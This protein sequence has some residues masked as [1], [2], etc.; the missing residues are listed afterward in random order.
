[1]RYAGR[2][3]SICRSVV[4]RDSCP[5]AGETA[6]RLRWPTSVK[7]SESGWRERRGSWPSASGLS[8]S[9]SSWPG[10]SRRLRGPAR[11]RT[12]SG[13]IGTSE[14]PEQKMS[15]DLLDRLIGEQ[16]YEEAAKEAARIR[17]EARR[18]GDDK[19]WAWALIREVQLRTA[20]H[21]YETVGPVP[22][23]RAVARFSRPAGHAGPV[24]CR[25]PRDLS[26]R[27]FLGDRPPRAHRID[28]PGRSQGLDLGPHQRGGLDGPH[29]R[30]E[31]QGRA[32]KPEGFRFPGYLGPGQLSRRDPGYPAGRRR[33]SHG[34]VPRRYELLDAAPVER[35][36][37]PRPGAPALPR[38]VGRR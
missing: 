38:A 14:R 34:Q 9:P 23:G 28:G 4:D 3:P 13:T 29:P 31:E 5:K 15:R 35:D 33:L 1:M 2:V 27:L 12:A 20:L 19:L 16:K 7:R 17:G 36:L 32:G 18:A 8:P 6:G 22:Q 25:F 21:G 11:R 30:L 24:L 10:W 37:A 26:F